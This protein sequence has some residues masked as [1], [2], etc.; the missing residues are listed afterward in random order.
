MAVQASGV[1]WQMLPLRGGLLIATAE[2]AAED[3]RLLPRP[4]SRT[5]TPRSAGGCTA[6]AVAPAGD[7]S[8][9]DAGAMPHVCGRA[10][11]GKSGAF[12]VRSPKPPPG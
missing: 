9:R 12:G 7:D 5:V 11:A 2:P 6:G 1:W 10:A 3:W 4:V 8:V